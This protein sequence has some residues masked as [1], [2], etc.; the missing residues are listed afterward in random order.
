LVSLT[1]RIEAALVIVMLVYKSGMRRIRVESASVVVVDLRFLFIMRVVLGR[2]ATWRAAK[3]LVGKR[4]IWRKTGH[5][6]SW[7]LAFCLSV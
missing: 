1:I 6:E 5:E 7:R 2:R 3:W 4:A